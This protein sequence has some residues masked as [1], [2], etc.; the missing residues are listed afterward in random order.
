MRIRRVA[1]PGLHQVGQETAALE[2]RKEFSETKSWSVGLR[3]RHTSNSNG[4]RDGS[5]GALEI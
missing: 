4:D 1:V 5:F 3:S 2:T